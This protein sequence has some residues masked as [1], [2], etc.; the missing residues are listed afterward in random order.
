[1]VLGANK[2]VLDKSIEPTTGFYIPAPVPWKSERIPKTWPSPPKT[3]STDRCAIERVLYESTNWFAVKILQNRTHTQA[4][5]MYPRT[6][7]SSSHFLPYIM[8]CTNG[9]SL[10]TRI[11]LVVSP[12]A[13]LMIIRCE[14]GWA[15]R[16]KK[17]THTH[18]TKIYI[19][20]PT[21]NMKH[22]RRMPFLFCFSFLMARLHQIY[23]YIMT[24]ESFKGVAKAAYWKRGQ[25][26]ETMSRI[27]YRPNKREGSLS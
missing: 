4:V 2:W 17:N 18:Q 25:P 8:P 16:R 24:I 22:S 13:H 7:T 11:P 20:E 21:K 14:E 10:S 19:H 26:T 1:M 3:L 23:T 9:Q 15:G 5:T 27:L 6:C 12:S